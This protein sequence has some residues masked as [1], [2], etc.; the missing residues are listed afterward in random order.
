MTISLSWLQDYLRLDASVWTVERITH[1]LTDLGLE[2]EAVDDQAAAL[3]GFVVGFVRERV[4][5]P[6]ANKLSVCTVDVGDGVDR[7]IVCG[8]PNVAG[9]Q[10]VPVALDGAV[11]PNGGFVIGR[12]TLRG[13][14]SQG[15]ICSKAE[16]NLGEDHDGIWVLGTDTDAASAR[17]AV[18]TP[19]AV[20]LG[21]TDGILHLGITPNRADAL[22]HIGVARDLA[23]VS[24]GEV[25][26]PAVDA[27][28]HSVGTT[29]V[30]VVID[31]PQLCRRF[32][33]RRIDGVRVVESPQWLKDRLTAIGLR[34]RNAIVDVT[35][36]VMHECGQPL[37][38][39]DATT[40]TEAT[41]VVQ[42]AERAGV[43]QYTTLDG[44]LR[45][46][47]PS[48][49][50]ICDT[51]GP[52]GI[53]G[54][55]GGEHSE[56]TDDTTSVLLESAWFAP[57]SVRRTAKILGLSTDASYRF[58]RGVDI[59]GVEWALDRATKLI[60]ELAGVPPADRVDAYPLPLAR[61][62]FRVRFATV[63]AINGIEV[64]D[65]AIVRMCRSIGCDVD[66]VDATGCTVTAPTWR[67]DVADEIDIVE[68]VMR[69]YGVDNIPVATH[70][71]VAMMAPF[72]PR[73]LRRGTIGP[74]MRR[75]FVDRGFNEVRTQVQTSPESAQA[76]GGDVVTLR[77]PLGRELSTLRTSI[78]PSLLSVAGLNLRHG[79]EKVRVVEHGKVMLRDATTELGVREEERVAVLMTGLGERHWSSKDREADIYDL[80]GVVRDAFGRAGLGHVVLQPDTADVSGSIWTVNRLAILDGKIRIGTLGQVEPALISSFDIDRT[81]VGAEWTVPAGEPMRPTYRPVGAYP[82]VRRDVA[83]I[84]EDRIDAG[85]IVATVRGASTDL[86]QDVDVFDVYRDKNVIGEGRKSI[87]IA[88]TMRSDERT[89]VDAEV[90][91]QV[92]RIVAA[93][94]QVHGATVRGGE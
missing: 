18:G 23:A 45:T 40:V 39:Y 92:A 68:E 89:L 3:R 65:D 20:H 59:D 15:M 60:A 25:E 79:A 61:P 77:N 91:D 44:K 55:M 63:R 88:M 78:I 30:K 27:T 10:Y 69:L 29:P 37:H 7:T 66:A 43:S 34:P 9:G 5:H 6:K 57:T 14:E 12:R 83:F 80:I 11:V 13:V 53:A 32:M 70:A 4:L 36:Y 1:A 76:G 38:A 71:Q 16:L 49:L 94:Q 31:D 19:L 33:V 93:V 58:E 54:V 21:T 72:M 28:P 41:F 84:V 82:A 35:N 67:M 8:A 50:L 81:V 85:M 86:L 75:F 64:E 52:V 24:G 22:S 47:E 87:G 42:T 2:V 62:R 48:M 26:R 51:A 17:P 73:A 56:I 74:S 46:L 90:D